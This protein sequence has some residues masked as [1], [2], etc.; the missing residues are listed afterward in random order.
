ME[1]R[2]LRALAQFLEDDHRPCLHTLLVDAYSDRPLAETHLGEEDD[3]FV[4]C[5]FFDRDGY[6]QRES[7]GN[8]TWVQ[9]GPRMRVHFADRPAEAPALNKIPMVRWKRHY[10]YN[11]STHDAWPRRL[12]RAAC[13]GRG[14]DLGGALPLQAGGGAPRQGGGRGAEE[15]ALPERPGVRPLPQRRCGGVLR[16]GGQRS[17]RGQPPACRARPDVAGAVVLTGIRRGRL[18]PAEDV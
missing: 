10:H 12:N 2:S 14:L 15:R 3:P 13:P 16:R 11:M 18:G 1:T 7:W 6:L 5:P 4:V 9:G 8:S 17:L